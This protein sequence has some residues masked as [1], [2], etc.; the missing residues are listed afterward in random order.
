M[1]QA[2]GSLTGLT[3]LV[4]GGAGGIGL[5]CAARL[6]QDGAAIVLTDRQTDGLETGRSKLKMSFPDGR[7]EISTGDALESRDVES[8]L[9]VAYAIQGRLDIIVSAVG[10]G[11]IRPLLLHDKATFCG[12]L[13]LNLIPTFLLIRHGVPM[14]SPGGAIVC[15]SSV[16]SKKVAPW[17]AAYSVGKGA[18]DSLVRS[19]AEEIGAAGLR[20]NA[21]RPGLT[22]TPMSAAAFERERVLKATIAEIPLGRTGEPSDIAEAVR[23]LA[24]PEASWVTGQSFAVDGGTE[25]RKSPDS[26]GAIAKIFGQEASDAVMRGKLPPQS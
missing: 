14:M 9:G 25:L 1:N 26:G 21:V 23:Y 17:M 22:R 11:T 10:G 8:A 7:V 15:I 20:I 19:A 3:A 16:A 13:N 18:L 2:P 5:A 4:S 24:G 12:E 6:L